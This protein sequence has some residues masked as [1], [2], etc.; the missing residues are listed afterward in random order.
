[1]SPETDP[2]LESDLGQALA[3]QHEGRFEEA[4]SR[5]REILSRHPEHVATWTNLGVALRTSRHSL[6]AL[7]CT[8]RALELR[9]GDPGVLG[10][11]GNVL[12][13]L[14]RFDESVEAHRRVIEADPT[15]A[16]A[17]YN[18]ALSLK[19]AGKAD[20]A[21]CEFEEALRLAPDM[22]QAHLDRSLALL[23]RG[24]WQEAWPEY[25]HRNDLPE[26]AN[27][28]FQEERWQG[29]DFGGKT[30]LIHREQGL[31][32]AMLA[33]R[34]MPQVKE[35]GGEVWL[36]CPG[37]VRRLFEG[38]PGVDR[39]LAPDERPTGVDLHCGLMSLPGLLGLTPD[40]I[41][42]PACLRPDP[43]P[44]PEAQALLARSGERFR[45]GIFWSGSVT[46]T[47]NAFRAAPMRPFLELAKHEGIQLYSLQTGAPR[48]QLTKLGCDPFVIDAADVLGDFAQT[49]AFV[50]QLDLVIMTDSALAHLTGSLG[51][52]VW[53]LLGIHPY[54][55][56][57]LE[58]ERMPWYASM[59]L[60][61]VTALDAWD[62]VFDEVGEALC[63]AVEARRGGRWPARV[64]IAAPVADL[65][66][67]T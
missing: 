49:A 24:R 36:Q 23:E 25:E 21:L 31:G 61:R 38:L 37:P 7:A 67:S 65:P 60:F 59:R 57:G 14:G 51:R 15:N 56:F 16:H 9:P 19:T 32:D 53:T 10:N 43:A 27:R 13:D 33:A 58:G 34:F 41:P 66:D 1:M 46:F 55:T 8:R 4:I 11:L 64:E 18:F 40:A 30:L 45:V 3:L 35:R 17:R 5:Y 44:T 50:S 28:D 42:A 62:A 12:K 48:Q 26:F 39:L 22:A 2:L 20:E 47:G 63:Q 52:P 29:E 54:W 6:A